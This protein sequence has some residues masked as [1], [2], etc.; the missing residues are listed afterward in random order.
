VATE[1]GDVMNGR[2]TVVIASALA[3][4]LLLGTMAGCTQEP[5]EV[6]RPHTTLFIGVDASGSFKNS[7]Y[8]DNAL[9]FLA[10]YIYGHLNEMGGLDKP[11]AMFVASVGG[12]DVREPK[13]FHPIHDFQNKDISQIEAE[14][15]K[16]FPPTD[17]VTD[18]NP[19]FQE[20]ARITKE[21]NLVLAPINIIVITDG[22]PDATTSGISAG[23]R[24]LYE[25][26]NL[27]P[28]EYLSRN[29]T[30]RLAYVSPKVGEQWRAHVPRERVRLW[31]VDGEI[32]KNWKEKMQPNLDLAE[33]DRFWK[34]L[35]DNVDFRVRSS[36]A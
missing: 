7:G 36:K 2:L 22:V 33:Q 14:L 18:F 24:V 29:V 5:A 32:M 19:F 35:R 13:S 28:L 30:L 26:I 9:S 10:H 27:K 31:T 15:R 34:W 8:Y 11:Q 17:R 12:K 21:R 20:V 1:E 23:S 25:K 16:W 6:R 3:G 4:T